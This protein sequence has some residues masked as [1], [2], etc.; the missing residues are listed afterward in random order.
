M[1]LKHKL[2]LSKS[3]K[4]PCY[5][6][7]FLLGVKNTAPTDRLTTKAACCVVVADLPCARSSSAP[8]ESH[9]PVGNM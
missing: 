5:F 9:S 3:D 2:T 4:V 6:S 1:L 8:V 7:I